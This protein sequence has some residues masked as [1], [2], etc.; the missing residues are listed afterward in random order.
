[1]TKKTILKKLPPVDNTLPKKRG[2][3]SKA[4]I[5]PEL[6]GE[7]LAHQLEPKVEKAKKTKIKKVATKKAVEIQKVDFE[8]IQEQ[9][10]KQIEQDTMKIRSQLA[11]DLSLQKA[12]IAQVKY[13][14]K[15]MELEHQRQAWNTTK[16]NLL[17][18]ISQLRALA[19]QYAPQE[20]VFAIAEQITSITSESHPGKKKSLKM[21]E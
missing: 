7:S 14:T 18:V 10:L 1:M 9:E 12:K 20:E 16:A 11:S 17:N 15:Y 6:V 3:K 2:K 8:A 5:E 21:P 13:R 4:K 19:I